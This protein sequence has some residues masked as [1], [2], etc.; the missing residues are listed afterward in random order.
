[1]S[2]THFIVFSMLL[3]VSYSQRS[4]YAGRD[5]IGYPK[6]EVTTVSTTTVRNQDTLG[7]KFGENQTTTTTTTERLPL[8]A[9]GDR[10]LVNRL[11]QLPQDKQPFWFLNWQELEKHRTRPHT[12]D[13]KP[14]VFISPV[15]LPPNTINNNQVAQQTNV[16]NNQ[17][18]PQNNL[19]QVPQQNAINNLVVQRPQNSL[20]NQVVQRPQAGLNNQVVQRPQAGLNNQVVQ[21]PQ[22]GLN[23]QVVQRPQAG[24]NNPVVQQQNAFNNQRMPQLN[25][26]S[27]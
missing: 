26:R 3:A 5:P 7:N 13:Q 9:L 10:E 4:P 8:E 19:N 2:T 22:A 15:T 17:V 27:F 24:L 6:I 21:R 23:N 20:N 12:F 18:Q 16:L 14:N 25:F 11:G 1:M